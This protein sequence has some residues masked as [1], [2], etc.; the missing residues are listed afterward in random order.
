MV[1]L[2]LKEPLSHTWNMIHWAFTQLKVRFQPVLAAKYRPS[3]QYLPCFQF[4]W[5]EKKNTSPLIMRAE[6]ILGHFYLLSRNCSLETC[7]TGIN[8]AIVFPLRAHNWARR[9]KWINLQLAWIKIC[10]STPRSGKANER[11]SVLF[12]WYCACQSS[13][14]LRT[15]TGYSNKH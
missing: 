15:S 1:F 5:K 13:Q 6:L 7:K 9:G 8:I 12:N 4:S 10:K 14:L 2:D 11:S 3:S